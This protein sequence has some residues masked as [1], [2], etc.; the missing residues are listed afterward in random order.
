MALHLGKH[1]LVRGCS[2]F[3]SQTPA[4]APGAKE[5]RGLEEEMV[6]MTDAWWQPKDESRQ[7][8]KVAAKY[9]AEEAVSSGKALGRLP[10]SPH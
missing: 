4:Y 3:D 9:L 5:K 10:Q 7:A 6:A 2:G 1:N 8:R